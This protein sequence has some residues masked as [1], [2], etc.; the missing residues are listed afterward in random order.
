MIGLG[1]RPA[2]TGSLGKDSHQ[3]LLDMLKR[4]SMLLR[5]LAAAF[6]VAIV[7]SLAN[8]PV[9]AQVT[10]D[11]STVGDPGN[12]PDTAVMNKP[13]GAPNLTNTTGYGTVDYAYRISTYHVTNTQ[14]VEFLNAVDPSGSNS[15]SLY[16]R[17]MSDHFISGLGTQVAT[18]GGIDQNLSAAVGSRY[19]VKAGQE[20]YP[21][22]WVQWSSAARFV[23]WL[24][25]GQGSGSTETGVYDVSV[26]DNFNSFATPPARTAGASIF[27][28][29]EDEYYKAA[30]YDPNKDGTGGYW[31]YG[32][33]TDL[34][35]ISEP[36]PGGQYSA[37]IG[38]GLNPGAGGTALTMAKTQA[39][40]DSSID[41]LTPVGAYT[42][43]TSAYGLYDVDG[44]VRNWTEGTITVFGN[45]LPVLRGGQ[46]R[47]GD[48]YA[49]AS[50]RAT[51]SGAGAASYASIGFR[52]AGLLE[53]T[54]DIVIDVTSGTVTQAQSG[55]TEIL[56]A[57]SL[58]KTGAGTVIF[59]AANSYTGPTTVSAGTLQVANAGGLSATVVT[60]SS[61]AT[62]AVASGT[63]MQSPSVIINGGTLSAVSLAVNSSA[64]IA[65]LAINAGTM[66]GS[67]LVTIGTGGEMAMP[68]DARVTVAIGGLSVDQASGGGTLDLG[69][70]QVSVAAGGISAVDLRTDIIAGRNGGSWNGTAGITSST[71]AA[72][73]GKRAVGYVVAGNGAATVSFAA[74]GDTNLNGTVD[75]FDLVA[76]NSAAKYGTGQPAV[77]SQ[78]DFNYDGVTNVFDLVGIN[79]AS[80]YG[81]GNYFPA[82]PVTG[83][84][85][86]AAVP[87]PAIGWGVLA[88]GV[89]GMAL[90][91]ARL[92]R[93]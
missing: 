87:E 17:N 22:V 69:G 49:G 42:S 47:Y 51:Y 64:G 7:A 66:T 71:A 32:T 4:D 39:A 74:L 84:G 88:L 24:S 43:A 58:T 54:T 52:V 83:L 50:Y 28:P 2:K 37:N 53:P 93:S 91:R 34:T 62:L 61:G 90:A 92:G 67:P 40:F 76:I 15:L 65:S 73:G 46:W 31:Q 25:N 57:D 26:F 16:S 78:G 60:V 29:S 13:A 70:G 11:W 85:S 1:T 77:W 6:L 18:T 27:L 36:A 8:G 59:D 12:V 68:Q 81:Q 9:M 41:Y 55:Y 30:Y 45:E 19:S 56:V 82:S 89:G 44:L 48:E 80:V 86:V 75:V 14:Y 3:E 35:P 63:T 10:F 23:N 21:A 38:A 33:Q 5:H 72:S 20:Q 79:S